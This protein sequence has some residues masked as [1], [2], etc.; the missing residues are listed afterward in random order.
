[1]AKILVIDDEEQL[2]DL[3]KQMLSRDGHDVTTA[4]DGVEGIR[5]FL[6]KLIS[7]I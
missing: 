3:L 2:R 6:N 5:V 4:F 7:L 1:M